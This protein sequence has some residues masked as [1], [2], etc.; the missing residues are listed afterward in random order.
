MEKQHHKSDNN[1]VSNIQSNNKNE[2]KSDKIKTGM[3]NT[4]GGSKIKMEHEVPIS[5]LIALQKIA[6]ET[7]L[8]RKCFNNH[9][10]GIIDISDRYKET[11]QRQKISKERL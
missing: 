8:V 7:E 1:L 11:Y 2:S 10:N 4:I 3:E 5:T 9:I 6:C